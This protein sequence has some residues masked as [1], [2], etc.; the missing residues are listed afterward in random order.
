MGQ[1]TII[2]PG[3]QGYFKLLALPYHYVCLGAVMGIRSPKIH[4]YRR[5]GFVN[6]SAS[7]PFRKLFQG[8]AID[9]LPGTL[10]RLIRGQATSP[11]T[12]YIGPASFPSLNQRYIRKQAHQ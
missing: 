10:E 11:H 5:E 8:L 3:G 12:L 1:Y 9:W 2:P 4:A 6:L 7:L